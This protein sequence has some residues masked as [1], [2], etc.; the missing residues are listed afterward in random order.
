MSD[1]LCNVIDGRDKFRSD[2]IEYKVSI[3]VA[4]NWRFIKTV[5]R[6]VLLR[7]DLMIHHKYTSDPF[8]NNG[9]GA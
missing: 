2:G 1:L 5:L 4:V 9:N 6:C 8:L 7:K 3:K